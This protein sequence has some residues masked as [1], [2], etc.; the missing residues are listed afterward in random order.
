MDFSDYL[1]RTRSESFKL[2]ASLGPADEIAGGGGSADRFPPRRFI[3]FPFR[4]SLSHRSCNGAPSGIPT[5]SV[6]LTWREE[7][8][9][10]ERL[11]Y[12][13]TLKRATFLPPSRP[14]QM[15]EPSHQSG[16]LVFPTLGYVRAVQAHF[17]LPEEGQKERERQRERERERERG[18]KGEGNIIGCLINK[19]RHFVRFLLRPSLWMA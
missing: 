9:R 6:S 11:K 16:T 14:D 10:G 17:T 8:R 18:G 5:P 7:R 1:C 2:A 4:F 19:A 3:P 13:S 12:S 15:R